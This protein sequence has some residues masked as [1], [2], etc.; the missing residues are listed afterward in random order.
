MSARPAAPARVGGGLAAGRP[1]IGR[2]TGAVRPSSSFR[3]AR[4]GRL[5][6]GNGRFHR[7]PF[8]GRRDCFDGFHCRNRFL[9]NS[10]LFYPYGYPLFDPFYGDTY[11][12]P[13][14]EAVQN[15]NRDA[16]SM[17]LALEVQRLS[18]RID[19][20]QQQERQQAAPRPQQQGSITAQPPADSTAFVFRDGRRITTQNYAIVGDNLYVMNAHTPKKIP[21]ADL[22]KAA[23]DQANATNGVDLRLQ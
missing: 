2:P 23:T 19:E 7:R 6:V 18:D 16:T 12:Q 9:L 1:A 8:F 3:S 4:S 10:G 20:M 5:I 22:D 15:D 11:S 13:A 21:L 14:Q 17:E